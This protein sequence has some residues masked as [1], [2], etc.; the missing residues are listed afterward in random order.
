MW[1]S[2]EGITESSVEFVKRL[3]PARHHFSG[4]FAAPSQAEQIHEMARELLTGELSD[5]V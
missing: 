3:Q 2:G 4:L 5:D 1:P